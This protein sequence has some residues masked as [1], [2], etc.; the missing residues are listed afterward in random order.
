MEGSAS[1]YPTPEVAREWMKNHSSVPL[2][3]IPEWFTRSLTRPADNGG[4]GTPPLCAGTR[5]MV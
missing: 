3:G 4:K 5:N 2:S 1:P